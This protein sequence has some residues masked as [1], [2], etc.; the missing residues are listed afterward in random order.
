METDASPR[1]RRD[2]LLAA[3]AC[4]VLGG[5]WIVLRL[6]W[7]GALLL[8]VAA[9]LGV[10]YQRL[11]QGAPKAEALAPSPREKAHSPAGPPNREKAHPPAGPPKGKDRKRR[12]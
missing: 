2:A 5:L 11:G 4:A 9:G 1:H 7:Q 12:R 10:L 6:Y 8:G 3:S